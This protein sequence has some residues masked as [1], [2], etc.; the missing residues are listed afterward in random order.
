MSERFT[1]HAA[2]YIL[3][4]ND[5]GDIL[6][7]QRNNTGFLDGYWDMPSGHIEPNEGALDA[8]IRELKEEVCLSAL[9]H[10]LRLIHVNQNF[11]DQPYINFMFKVDDWHGIPAIGE[12]DK[13]SGLKFFQTDALPD[14]CSLAVRMLQDAGFSDDIAFSVV[15][16]DNFE[17]Y[18]GEPFD[19]L[20]WGR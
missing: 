6:L 5:D 8:A 9:P 2:V 20:N 19:P 16:A 15:R 11:L 18:M 3:V 17:T 14:K 1:T 4:L 10:N 12:P 7:H 13:C